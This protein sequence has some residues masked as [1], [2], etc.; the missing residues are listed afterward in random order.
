MD[1]FVNR[2]LVTLGLLCALA[3]LSTSPR[4]TSPTPDLPADQPDQAP[5]GSSLKA[6]RRLEASYLIVYA[7]VMLADWLQGSYLFSLYHDHYG[8]S[9]HL[10]SLLFV[11]GFATAA[12]AAFVVGRW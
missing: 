1:S 11:L 6:R 4:R 5:T 8:L 12:V 10:V 7:L 2:T 3:T 9:L